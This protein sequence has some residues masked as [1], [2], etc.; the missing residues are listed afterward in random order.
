MDRGNMKARSGAKRAATERPTGEYV[1]HGRRMVRNPLAWIV[2]VAN[3]FALV[4]CGGG[5][6]QE[7]HRVSGRIT[8]AGQPVSFGEVLFTPDATQG[9]AGAQGIAVITNGRYDT[10]GSRAP[11]VAAGPVVVRVTAL[12]D[13]N[14]TL[15]CEHEFS[16][17]V[18]QGGME[19][20]IEIPADAG[21]GK[22]GVGQPGNAPATPKI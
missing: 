15:L 8:F 9:N 11:G 16:L 18:S 19:R 3:L 20:D 7:R 14:G 17:E 12:A 21:K 1:A 10:E 4:A 22:P 13:A 5:D 2:L 6:S